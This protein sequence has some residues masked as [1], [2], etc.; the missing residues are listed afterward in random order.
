MKRGTVKKK[1]YITST[2][3]TEAKHWIFFVLFL[4]VEEEQSGTK[5]AESYSRI[6]FSLDFSL[7]LQFKGIFIMQLL[8]PSPAPQ[9]AVNPNI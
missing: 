2:A 9:A 5:G 8:T 7:L 3:L 4:A 6:Y 1:Y